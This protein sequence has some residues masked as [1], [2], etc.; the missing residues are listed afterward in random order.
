[1]PS[2]GEQVSDEH[3]LLFNCFGEFYTTLS[4]HMILQSLLVALF[5]KNTS[6][7]ERGFQTPRELKEM[8]FNKEKGLYFDIIHCL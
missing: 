4:F 5:W 2:Q 3:F 6:K 8:M 1:M 7:K